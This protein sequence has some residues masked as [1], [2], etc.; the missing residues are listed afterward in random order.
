MLNCLFFHSFVAVPTTLVAFDASAIL[1]YDQAV[2]APQQIYSHHG[3][4]L[5]PPAA[6]EDPTKQQGDLAR[7]DTL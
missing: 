2:V 5:V 1:N 3:P 4:G 6:H 7:N